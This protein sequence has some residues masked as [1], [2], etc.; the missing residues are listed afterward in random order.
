MNGAI[1]GRSTNAITVSNDRVKVIT[2]ENQSCTSFLS[3]FSI[4]YFFFLVIFRNDRSI[5]YSSVDFTTSNDD[6]HSS[7]VQRNELKGT[8]VTR[9]GRGASAN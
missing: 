6:Q 3:N 7:L 4:G 9:Y 8:R 2:R 5:G 1:E